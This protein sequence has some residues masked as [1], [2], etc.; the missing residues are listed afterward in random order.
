MDRGSIPWEVNMRSFLVATGIALLLASVALAEGHVSMEMGTP[1]FYGRIDI[2]G[3]P[4]PHP[5]E[6]IFPTPVIITPPR[7]RVVAPAPV[8][9]HVPPG[10]EKQWNKHCAAY[11]ACGM[12]VLFVRDTWYDG[13]YVPA[14]RTKHHGGPGPAARDSGHGGG[15]GHGGG[16]GH[17]HGKK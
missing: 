12:P 10:H 7:V 5:P 1:G 6:L 13:V 11:H 14:Y 3:L 2:G 9:L 8:Y 16:G 4:F 17:G 15:H